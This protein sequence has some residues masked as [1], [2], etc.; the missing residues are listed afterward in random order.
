M[1]ADP[2][3]HSLP[4][5]SLDPQAE[6]CDRCAGS[7][8]HAAAACP[9]CGASGAGAALPKDRIWIHQ[10]LTCEPHKLEDLARA[11]AVD[12]WQLVDTIYEPDRV[13]MLRCYFRKS[14][15]ADGR[16]GRDRDG[17]FWN[18]MGMRWRPTA[19]GQNPAFERRQRS[20]EARRA[21][22]EA[23]RRFA[24]AVSLTVFFLYLLIAGMILVQSPGFP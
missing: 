1:S 7:I 24:L 8:E 15:P 14:V 5:T 20:N 10:S 18:W 2:H 12:G 22:A 11:Q 6:H 21:R 17:S 23:D 16:M 13:G 3:F 19:P 9:H 4:A